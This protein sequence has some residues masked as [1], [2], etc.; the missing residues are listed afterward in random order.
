MTAVNP[1]AN[2]NGSARAPRSCSASCNNPRALL[3]CYPHALSPAPL[4]RV[5]ARRTCWRHRGCEFRR[6]RCTSDASATRA[7]TSSPIGL[8]LDPRTDSSSRFPRCGLRAV[9][10]RIFDREADAAIG[11]EIAFEQR[12]N[13]RR[14]ALPRRAANQ[15]QSAARP[16]SCSTRQQLRSRPVFQWPIG[17]AGR[18]RKAAQISPFEVSRRVARKRMPP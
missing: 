6:P 12:R 1:V 18:R 2:S 17:S 11:F 16:K 14:L 9:F 4:A 5:A 10:D 7:S 8:F 15:N 3:P 13:R